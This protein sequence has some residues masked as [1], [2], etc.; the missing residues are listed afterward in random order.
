MIQRI[1]VKKFITGHS[2]D[3]HATLAKC[4][5]YFMS[6]GICL[7]APGKS[8]TDKE[9]MHLMT[10][11]TLCLIPGLFNFWATRGPCRTRT[12][13]HM[14]AHAGK[15]AATP[16][17]CPTLVTQATCPSP[18]SSTDSPTPPPPHLV[19][20]SPIPSHEH[21]PFAAQAAQ[22][23]PAK[24]PCPQKQGQKEEARGRAGEPEEP[25]HH[26][27]SNDGG[28]RGVVAQSEPMNCIL[29][30]QGP[31]AAHRLPVG[32]ALHYFIVCT[33]TFFFLRFLNKSRAVWIFS[34]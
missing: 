4:C 10:I 32:P 1:C 25:G 14:L 24:L 26:G 31:H 18:P 6:H 23:L 3:I 20:H 30:F 17:L 8:V 5:F 19:Q 29:A 34:W 7:F 28:Q 27:R 16:R 12:T 33:M 11:V 9:Q 22:T 21:H 2:Q 15:Q 13:C